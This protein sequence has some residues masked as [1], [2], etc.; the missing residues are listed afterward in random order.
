[1][2]AYDAVIRS[3]SKDGH[4][5]AQISA[6]LDVPQDEITAIM[7]ASTGADATEQPAAAPTPEPIAEAL[8]E[9]ADLLA[10][11]AAHDDQQIRADGKQAAAVL[12]GLRERRAV[13]AEL[14]QI[15]TEKSEL[16]ERL[17]AL[18][19]RESKLRPQ[20]A[21]GKRRRQERD[22]EPSVVRV[23]ARENGYEVPDRGQIPKKVLEAWR[24]TRDGATQLAA[25]N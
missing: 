8:P 23:W 1:M 19:A 22:Y 15:T 17:A 4:S 13:D 24:R 5:P 10:W 11:A 3:M 9:V 2:D 21:S 6:Q 25:V 16:Q 20:P 12:A 7:A 14:E 18:Q